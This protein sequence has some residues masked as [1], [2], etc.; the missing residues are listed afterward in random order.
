MTS[1]AADATGSGTGLSMTEQ[2]YRN[3]RRAVVTCAVEPG[4]WLS[5]TELRELSGFARTPTREAA[6]RL[7]DEALMEVLP[8]RGYRVTDVTV[9]GARQLFEVSEPL[10]LMSLRYAHGR[11]PAERL[12]AL[13]RW[14]DEAPPEGP[15]ATDW[16]HNVSVRMSDTLLEATANPWLAKLEQQLAGHLHRLW[17]LTYRHV[18]LRDV[19]EQGLEPL[20]A[21]LMCEDVE[22]ATDRLRASHVWIRETT[23]A[24]L[25]R[26]DAERASGRPGA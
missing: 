24:V 10:R 7:V 3:L 13:R 12:D 19:V 5:E 23:L 1:Q 18:P 17:S 22:A 26:R 16:I 14:I 25:E 21:A 6:S 9:T 15:A 4:A 11:V 2:A 8:R 20:L